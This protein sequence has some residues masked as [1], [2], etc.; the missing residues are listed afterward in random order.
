MA[1][2]KCPECGKEV[3]DK[4]TACINCGFP[5]SNIETTSNE[6]TTNENEV[7]YCDLLTGRTD[8]VSIFNNGLEDGVEGICTQNEFDYKYRVEEGRAYVTYDGGTTGYII[9]GDYLVSP[10]GKHEGYIPDEEVFN[11]TCTQKIDFLGKDSFI[12]FKEDGTYKED[13]LFGSG[14]IGGEYKRK[15]SLLV[16]IGAGTGGKPNG[17]LIYNNNYYIGCKIKKEKVPELKELFSQFGVASS[18]PTT[19]IPS[20]PTVPTVKCPYCQSS[21]TKKISSTAKAINVALFGI[22]GNKRKYQWHCNNCNSDF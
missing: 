15:G 11:V 4:A 2:I 8:I 19:T 6:K 12:T 13:S 17:F 22:F 18:M 14:I 3:S 16:Q 20:R 7:V 10:N 5:L 9:Y 1:L 21:N